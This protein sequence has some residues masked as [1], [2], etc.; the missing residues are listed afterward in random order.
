MSEKGFRGLGFGRN[1][2]EQEGI[3]TFSTRSKYWVKG[4]SGLLGG[5]EL[6][7]AALIGLSPCRNSINVLLLIHE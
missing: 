6:W 3:Q 5:S 1:V 2:E 4:G 7:R